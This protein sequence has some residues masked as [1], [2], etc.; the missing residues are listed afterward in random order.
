MPLREFQFTATEAAYITDL[1]LREVQ[2]AFDEDWFDH[3]PRRHIRGLTR[4]QL[5]P[6]ELVHL[7]LVKDVGDQVVFHARTK[8]LIHRQ[9]RERMPD[10]VLA[11][12]DYLVL[13]E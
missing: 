9:I 13:M 11:E 4:R 12:A 7:R 1:S 2:K 10:I 3:A 6:A 8:K 5:G